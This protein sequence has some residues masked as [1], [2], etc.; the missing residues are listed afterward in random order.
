MSSDSQCS[1]I[2]NI[3]TKSIALSI[4]HVN[5][6]SHAYCTFLPNTMSLCPSLKVKE[7]PKPFK[8]M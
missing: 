5:I 8:H 3:T 1:R 2:M 7:S 4:N 6:S